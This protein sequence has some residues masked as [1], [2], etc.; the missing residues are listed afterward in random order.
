MSANNEVIEKNT[1]VWHRG[2]R[3]TQ[4]MVEEWKWTSRE[5]RLEVLILSYKNRKGKKF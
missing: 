4:R 3:P 2:G 1:H 5:V